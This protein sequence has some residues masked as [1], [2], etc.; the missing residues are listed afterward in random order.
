MLNRN[1]DDYRCWKLPFDKELHYTTAKRFAVVLCYESV[2][3][4]CTKFDENPLK[5]V[6]SRV[7][8]R[9]LRSKV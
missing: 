4:V 9:K 3:K 2:V 5:D 1:V 7:L 8:T 6:D